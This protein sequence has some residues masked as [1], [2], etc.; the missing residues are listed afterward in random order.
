MRVCTDTKGS[1]MTKIRLVPAG[2][3]ISAILILLAIS[4]AAVAGDGK[5]YGEPLSGS[6]TIK[7]SVLMADP[8]T[9]VGKTVRIEGQIT[10]VCEKRGCWMSLASDEE[11]QELRI[12]VDD[13]VLVFPMEAKGKRAIAEG[14]FTKIEMTME[15]TLAYKK[16]HAE[17]HDEEF[18]PSTVTE[19]MT[20]YQIKATGAVIR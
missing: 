20:Y 19:P 8:D 10:G 5:V 2:T 12:K 18:D 11:S 15:Q 13:G 9:Y 16:Q 17:E 6:D 14:E 7:I 1:F 3:T 4:S